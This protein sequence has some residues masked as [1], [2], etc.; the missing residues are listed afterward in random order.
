VI[1]IT[2]ALQRFCVDRVGLPAA[3]VEVVHYGLDALPPPWGD[4]G[5]V[6]LADG[7]RV[8]L[9]VGRL[10]EQK[11]VDVAIRAFARVREQ[12][13]DTVL[14]VLG[15]GPERARLEA[16]P[17]DGVYLPGRVGDVAA[18]YRRAEM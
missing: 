9:C 14:V 10:T 2:E 13:P 11:G 1:A 6:P 16:L 12:V 8:L 5:D 17:R 4:A 15:E 18:W 7:A 3:K